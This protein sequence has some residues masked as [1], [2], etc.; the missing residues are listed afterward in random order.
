MNIIFAIYLSVH[1]LSIFLLIFLSYYFP[2]LL[3]TLFI[4]PL[5]TR[6][7]LFFKRYLPCFPFCFWQALKTCKESVGEELDNPQS[8]LIS[9]YLSFYLC[10]FNRC[11]KLI[12]WWGVGRSSVFASFCDRK[13]ERLDRGK[14]GGRG[15]RTPPSKE[16]VQHGLLW[17]AQ[18]HGCLRPSSCLGTM[19]MN[20]FY[21]HAGGLTVT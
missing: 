15:S 3:S 14:R 21:D 16:L 5:T 1:F 12:S 20:A 7:C 11:W 18:S 19:A 2:F 13:P 4:I 10:I 8:S 6:L 9:L 17:T